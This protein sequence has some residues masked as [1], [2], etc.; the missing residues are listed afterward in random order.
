MNSEKAKIRNSLWNND[1]KI[2]K[3]YP[4][5]Y[6]DKYVD[7]VIVGGGIAGALT[8]FFLAKDGYKIAVV[9]KNLVGFR[10]TS[11][12]AGIITDFTEELYI[13][14]YKNLKENVKFNIF[15]LNN[16]ANALL[17]EIA[18]DINYPELIEKVDYNIVNTKHFQKGNMKEESSVRTSCGQKAE[19]AK[20]TCTVDVRN[21]ARLINPYELTL[22]IF[23]YLSSFPNVEIYENT[24]VKNISEQRNKITLEQEIKVE[25]NNGFCITSH[26]IIFTTPI[27]NLGINTLPYIEKFRRFEIVSDTDLD[28][29]ICK[30][31]LNDIPIYLRVKDKKAIVTGLDLKYLAKM[32]DKKQ[33]EPLEEEQGKKLLNSLEKIY[34]NNTFSNVVCLSTNIYKS[35]DQLPIISE[36]EDFPNAY[37]NIGMGSSKIKH[38][39]IGGYL[40]KEAL[41]GYYK[42]EMNYFKIFR[43][44]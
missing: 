3:T 33:I 17:D 2:T 29:K 8:A 11:L 36:I 12:D 25:S 21:Y 22:K 7:V 34:P 18:V 24:M 40:L 19:F 31:I 15:E 23:E 43:E 37:L 9:E 13:K 32:E 38:A 30:K 41:K 4:Y 39:V 1:T 5:L 26:H 14:S 6:E 44:K 28:K 10:N 42:K 20:E 27:P 35:V 16:K